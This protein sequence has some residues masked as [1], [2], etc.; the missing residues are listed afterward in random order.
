MD[1]TL[2]IDKVPI[3]VA[4]SERTVED[5]LVPMLL[6]WSASCRDLGRRIVVFLGAAPGAGKSVLAAYLEKLSASIPDAERVQAVGMDGFHHTNAFLESHSIEVD[7][8]TRTLRSVKGWPETFRSAELQEKV[9]ALKD[10]DTVLFPV[11]DRNL[12]DP[13]ED[14][15]LVDAP[16]VLIE[17]MWMLYDDPSWAGVQALADRRIA[18]LSRID[19]LRERAVARKVR[20]GMSPEDARRFFDTVDCIAIR[21]ILEHMEPADRYLES[22]ESMDLRD[23]GS[24]KPDSTRY[25]PA[26][27][28]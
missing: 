17:G 1:S 28:E 23:L 24:V 5:V 21:R 16:I 3:R 27:Q 4:F 25:L 13:V 11:Y 14:A 8:Q 6:E 26:D 10:S 12:H 7:G 15:L 19:V 2:I 18:L 9:R 22:M 20:G